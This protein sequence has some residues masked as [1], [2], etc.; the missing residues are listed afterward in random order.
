MAVTERLEEGAPELEE[1]EARVSESPN[2]VQ[3]LRE[4]GW[5]LYGRNRFEEAVEKFEQAVQRFPDDPETHYALGLAHKAA[6]TED[7]ARQS[8][9]QTIDLAE[10]DPKKV[11]SNMMLVLAK[12]QLHMLEHGTWDL[13]E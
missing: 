9:R 11:R 8:F 6:G 3:P 4:L 1:L 2:E 7:K 12:R 13:V 10:D 5:A